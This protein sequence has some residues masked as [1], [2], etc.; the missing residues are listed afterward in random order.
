M[1]SFR[2]TLKLRLYR[3]G[4]L[5]IVR[6][7]KWRADTAFQNNLMRLNIFRERGIFRKLR[8]EIVTSGVPQVSC[9][10]NRNSGGQA[11]THAKFLFLSLA[12]TIGQGNR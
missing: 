4:C 9:Q 2:G 8:D 1:S 6:H 7:E 5:Q 11:G 3:D 12:V 10:W